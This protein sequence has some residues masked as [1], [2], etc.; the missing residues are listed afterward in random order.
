MNKERLRDLFLNWK[1]LEFNHGLKGV[2]RII[3]IALSIIFTIVSFTIQNYYFLSI[4]LI[5]LF[6][7]ILSENNK[8]YYLKY[9][10]LFEKV[11]LGKE[12]RTDKEWTDFLEKTK[13]LNSIYKWILNKILDKKFRDEVRK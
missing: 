11:K 8:E 6:L 10:D 9:K 7:Q 1:G 3:L 12:H 5:I 2:S 13:G 4:S